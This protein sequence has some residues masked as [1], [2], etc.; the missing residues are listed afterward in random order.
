MQVQG[1]HEGT[2]AC[3]LVQDAHEGAWTHVRARGR[4]CRR[5]VRMRAHGAH[6]THER[7]WARMRAHGRA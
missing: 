5:R 1:E 6:G 4:A 2:W 7:P 3:M